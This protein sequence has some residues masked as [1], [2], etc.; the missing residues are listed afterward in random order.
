MKSGKLVVLEGIDGCGKHTQSYLLR[1][2]LVERGFR[3][4]MFSYPSLKGAFGKEIDGFLHKKINLDKRAQ[5]LLFT[6][7]IMAEQEQIRK[8]LRKGYVVILNRYITSTLAYQCRVE[9]MVKKIEAVN[10]LGLVEPDAILLLDISAE[11]SMK[12]KYRQKNRNNKSLDRFEENKR[13]LSEVRRKYFILSKKHALCKGWKII[14]SEKG[15]EEVR[16]QIKN[17]ICYVLK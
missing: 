12:R 6:L 5:F 10:G 2:T 4:K 13:F 7:N 9:E 16:R 14:D 17:Y 11:T 15:K 8:A 1:R 3:V